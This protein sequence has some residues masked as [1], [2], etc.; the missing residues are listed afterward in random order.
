MKKANTL[1]KLI[2]ATS[3]LV[4][5]AAASVA[6]QASA[7]CAPCP[8]WVPCPPPCYPPPCYPGVVFID[9]PC[10]PD[11]VVIEQPVVMPRRSP[12]IIEERRRITEEE[13]IDRRRDEEERIGNSTR[14][15]SSRESIQRRRSDEQVTRRVN[16]DG[17]PY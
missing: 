1:S 12:S 9:Q 6:T 2:Q 13:I 5:L 17:Y 14:R 10:Y 11:M 16:Y 15:S 3:L 7:Q 8:I 4:V